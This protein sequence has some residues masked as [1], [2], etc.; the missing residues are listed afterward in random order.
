MCLLASAES[1]LLA[2]LAPVG[3]ISSLKQPPLNVTR[4]HWKLVRIF[5]ERGVSFFTLHSHPSS[6]ASA[7]ILHQHLD[8]FL[9]VRRG[10]YERMPSWTA[11]TRGNKII[12]PRPSSKV[13]TQSIPSLRAFHGLR[14]MHNIADA[15]ALLDVPVYSSKSY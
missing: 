15:V 10:A 6:L 7:P 4:W 2:P 1:A 3:N 8:L 5:P 12:Y 14:C 13:A 11:A 9:E